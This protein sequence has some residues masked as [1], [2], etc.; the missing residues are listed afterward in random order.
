[1]SGGDGKML[2]YTV[3]GALAAFGLVCTVWTVCGFFL[4]DLGGELLYRG[5]EPVEFARRYLWLREMRLIHCQLTV[6]DPPKSW[7][8]WLQNQGIGIW[9]GENP[10]KDRGETD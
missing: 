3:I 6:A 8:H 9:N 5:P 2:A 7:L 1:M 10:E 4:R